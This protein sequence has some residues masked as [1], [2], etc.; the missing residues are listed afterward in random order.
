MSHKMTYEQFL[1]KIQSRASEKAQR[2]FCRILKKQHIKAELAAA[3][4]IIIALIAYLTG[5]HISSF[6]ALL[7][8]LPVL[9]MDLRTYY[10][11]RKYGFCSKNTNEKLQL[12]R[13]AK[14]CD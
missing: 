11:E 2:Q 12:S 9:A 3:A 10:L 5:L 1:Q 4:L 13:K 8:G 6:G 14:S 7:I